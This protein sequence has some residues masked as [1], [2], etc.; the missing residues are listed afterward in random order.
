MKQHFHGLL[1]DRYPRK[2]INAVRRRAHFAINIVVGVIRLGEI[3]MAFAA[4]D[5]KLSARRVTGISYGSDRIHCFSHLL[6]PL[7]MLKNRLSVAIISLFLRKFI[8][9]AKNFHFVV[10]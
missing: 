2:L 7:K 1:H 10:L 5:E 9:F 4:D 8:F 3:G 6:I